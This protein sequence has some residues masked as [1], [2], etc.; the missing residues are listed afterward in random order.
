MSEQMTVD[1]VLEMALKLE[2]QSE[3][4]YRQA[5]A[6]VETPGGRVLLEE[7]AEEEVRHRQML[8]GVQAT[9]DHKRI[10]AGPAPADLRV[11]DFLTDPNLGPESTTQDI[12]LFAI[13]REA[14]AVRLYSRMLGMYADTAA[15]PVL[16]RLVLEEKLH[17]E[18]LEKEYDEFVNRDN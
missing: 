18:R 4:M 10:G 15:V 12:L 2:I 8:E 13:K 7:L 11:A 14:G 5:A 9:G 1:Q 6:Q 3:K 17:K 16:D